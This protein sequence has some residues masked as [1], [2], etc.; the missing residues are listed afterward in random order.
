MPLNGRCFLPVQ[1]LMLYVRTS[2]RNTG[3]L[4][5]KIKLT[6]KSEGSQR[7]AVK[8]IAS[9]MNFVSSKH[10]VLRCK[11]CNDLKSIITN[12][13]AVPSLRQIVTVLSQQRTAFE[14]RQYGIYGG[15]I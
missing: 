12:S 8:F 6:T 14:R 4:K 13:G 15:E 5:L 10:A 2:G 11:T 1:P 7:H 3:A 9:Y